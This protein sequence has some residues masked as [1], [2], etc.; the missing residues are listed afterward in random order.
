[1]RTNTLH[2]YSESLF[3]ALSVCGR[4]MTWSRAARLCLGSHRGYVPS[5]SVQARRVQRCLRRRLSLPRW[6]TQRLPGRCTGTNG[7]RS[8]Q[9]EQDQPSDSNLA[10]FQH[11]MDA[12]EA[13]RSSSVVL[14]CA[15]VAVVFAF[16]RVIASPL[17]P[18]QWM[19]AQAAVG[20]GREIY[21]LTTTTSFIFSSSSSNL[22]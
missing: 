2:S 22:G 15:G 7:D 3:L 21:Q 10:D 12:E 11:P 20:T 9:C 16:C 1:M 17:R 5:A 4:E 19:W 6:S 18:T 13:R 14:A 8:Q